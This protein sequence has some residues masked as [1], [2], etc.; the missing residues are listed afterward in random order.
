MATTSFK[1]RTYGDAPAWKDFLNIDEQTA[2]MQAA[3]AILEAYHA[4]EKE[5]YDQKEKAIDFSF[6]QEFLDSC[7]RAS[8]ETKAE[9]LSGG[10][11]KGAD[12][13]QTPEVRLEW[14]YLGSKMF[15]HNHSDSDVS[16]YEI[17]II[18]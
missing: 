15:S 13:I 7:E 8:E 3:A 9:L 2:E 6:S 1:F 16:F 11:E 18:S 5:I 17:R 14:K 10:W 12:F 4:K